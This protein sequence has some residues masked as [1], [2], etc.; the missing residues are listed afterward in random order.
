M[1]KNLRENK[2]YKLFIWSGAIICAF[3]IFRQSSLAVM[4]LNWF[5]VDDFVE[6]WA[7]GSLNLRGKNPYAPEELLL[8][9]NLAGRFGTEAVMM[10][11][12]P[13]TLPLVMPLGLLSYQVSRTIWMLLNIGLIFI[14]SDILW[15]LYGGKQGLR[16][17]SW[18]IGF[19]FIPVLDAI[20]KGQTGILILVGIVGFLFFID[21]KKNILA[22]ISL[23]LLAIKPHV[24]Y[25]F[26]LAVFLW[27][28]HNLKWQILVG[29]S[30]ALAGSMLLTTISN[31]NVISQ[32]LYAV[33]NYPP[34]DWA[35]PTIGGIM[36][37]LLGGDYFWLQFF[38]TILGVF[39]L[40]V[41][42]SKRK[43]DWDWFEQS[44]LII[45]VSLVTTAYGWS[46]DQPAALV[47]I[48]PIFV[49]ITSNP[50]E[51]A[52]TIIVSTYLLIILLNVI[53]P[54][55][56]IFLFWFAPVLLIWFLSSQ[57]VL[58]KLPRLI[59]EKSGDIVP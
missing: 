47:A 4:E 21:K 35:T 41:Y 43:K 9:Q 58:R 53:S 27:S 16:W 28:L 50:W 45:L 11:N 15:R 5:E 10:W 59:P 34:T 19:S 56:E 36:R 24:A 39:W 20:K 1:I 42:F 40:F 54:E 6:Y 52:S 3:L 51:K 32:Y 17:I 37:L 14:S 26:L 44:P 2:Y 57:W 29:F 23:A 8:M 22:G 33:S 18:M 12:P 48:L 25:L 7:A 13:W 38:P 49:V 30:L 46:F 31:P 55:N